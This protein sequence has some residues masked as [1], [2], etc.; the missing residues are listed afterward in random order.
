MYKA[1]GILALIC[2]ISLA[3]AK[4]ECNI[5]GWPSYYKNQYMTKCGYLSD[6]LKG[7][8]YHYVYVNK[9]L[10]ALNPLIIKVGGGNSP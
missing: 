2:L 4:Y 1:I 9:S 10:S 7:Y 5:T 6:P 8:N 3:A